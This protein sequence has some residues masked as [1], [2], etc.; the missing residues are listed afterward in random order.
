M[1]KYRMQIIIILVKNS[2]LSLFIILRYIIIYNNLNGSRELQRAMRNN[3]HSGYFVH[4]E[5]ILR[6][7]NVP[8]TRSSNIKSYNLV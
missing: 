3:T 5:K 1:P 6:G 4:F 8:I 7:P 2:C